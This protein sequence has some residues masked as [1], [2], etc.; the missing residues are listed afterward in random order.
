MPQFIDLAKQRFHR[1][2]VIRRSCDYRRGIPQWLCK[3]DCGKQTIVRGGQL[4]TGNTKSCGC[5]N[6]D[7]HRK[8][9]LDRNTTHGLAGSPTHNCWVNIKQRCEN[10]KASGYS[11][12]GAKG[13]RLCDR[14]R[15][16]ENFL[17]DMGERPTGM[18]IDRIE[19]S[20]GYEPGNCRWATQRQQQNNRSNNTH[21]TFNDET[22]TI[23][24]WS[25][26]TGFGRTTIIHRLDDLG[27]SVEEALTVPPDYGNKSRHR[28]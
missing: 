12:Y 22:L 15:S 27:W 8:V 16:F 21:I 11:K 10:P 7:V 28:S 5:L 13:I 26:R 25:R 18:T 2:T 14:W 24:E 3:C 23:M 1:L 6:V 19:N 4:T 9:C 17:A 20:K